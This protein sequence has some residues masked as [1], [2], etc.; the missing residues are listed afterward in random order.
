MVAYNARYVWT[1]SAVAALGGFLFGYDWVVIGG[2]KPFYETYFHLTTATLIGWANSC[3]LVGCLAGSLLS[4]MI[5]DRLGRKKCSAAGRRT[6]SLSLPCSLAGP[7]LSPH[8]SRGASSVAL[9]SDSHRTSLRC[10]SPK[11]APRSG[12][13]AWFVSTSSPS[14][15]A[16]LARKSSTG[17]SARA[18]AHLFSGS[19]SYPGTRST[20]GA[21]CS[22][23]SL[24]PQCCYLFWRVSSRRARAG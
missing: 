17:R 24:C 11:S 7:T 10:T 2:A 8:S 23:R 19:L 13:D 3:A 18:A 14:Y 4:G 1:I 9:P 6:L 20:A 21:G 12:V 5:G 15:A 16:S 22:P